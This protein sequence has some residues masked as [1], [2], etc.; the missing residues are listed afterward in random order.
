MG[1]RKLNGTYK[2][3]WKI[4]ENPDGS[5][6]EKDKSL[7]ESLLSISGVKISN[8]EVRA[9]PLGEKAGHL[10]GYVQNV[11]AEI[12]KEKRERTTMLIA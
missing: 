6:K 5:V 2:N 4:E 10:T 9:Y 8:T 3:Y 12:L 7:Q 11:N 1:K